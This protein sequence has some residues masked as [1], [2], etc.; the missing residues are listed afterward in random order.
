MVPSFALHIGPEPVDV[1]VLGQAAGKTRTPIP[2][3]TVL[4]RFSKP[5]R[6][7]GNKNEAKK[8]LERGFPAVNPGIPSQSNGSRV[9]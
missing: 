1:S 7:F 9:R 3:L 6:L 4:A 8:M 5:T 2:L